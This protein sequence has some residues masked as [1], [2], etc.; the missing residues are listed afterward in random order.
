MPAKSSAQKRLMEAAAHTAGGYGGVPQKV[1]EE[2]VSKDNERGKLDKKEEHEA[3]RDH[4]ER[5][6]M[7][8]SAFLEGESRKYPVKVKRDGE[9]KYDRDLLLAAEREAAM[10]DHPDLEA[11]AKRIRE[12]EFDHGAHDDFEE[13]KHPRA[14]NGEFGSAGGSGGGNESRIHES[15]SEEKNKGPGK[16]KEAVYA[17]EENGKRRWLWHDDPDN[18]GMGPLLPITQ[19]E[20]KELV[21]SGK[22]TMRAHPDKYWKNVHPFARN[23]KDIDYSPEDMEKIGQDAIRIALDRASVRTIDADGRL[24]VA[25]SHISKATV[26]PYMGNEIPGWESLG[27]EPERV[28]QLLRDPGE[29]AQAAPTFNNIP[30]LSRHVP[31]SADEPRKDIVVGSTGTDAVFEDPYL[32]NSLVVWDSPAIGGIESREQYELSCAYRYT[33]DMTPGVYEGVPYEGVMRDIVGNHV[34]LVEVGRAGPDVVVSDSNPF[35]ETKMAKKASSKTIAVRAAV[36][37][38]LRPRLAADAALDINTLIGTVG[39]TF[40]EDDARRLVTAIQ[41]RAKLAQGANLNDLHRVIMDAAESEKDD[42]AEDAEE[43]ESE[44]ERKKREEAEAKAAADAE[45]EEQRKKE[46]EGKAMDAAI[47]AAS[48]KAEADAI[49]RMQA[50]SKAEKEVQPIIGDV[51]AM[52]SAE[53]VYKLALDHLGIEVA[54]VDPSAYRAMVRMHLAS[55]EGKKTRLAQDAAKGGDWMSENFPHAAPLVRI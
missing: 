42:K 24:H 19:K 32:K 33:P 21:S 7:P 44:E 29:L 22:A 10:H 27:L 51:A 3:E 39:A 17:I 4:K 48:A 54:D 26:N 30:L 16:P 55:N 45:E 1:G 14:E 53:A 5:E 31:V 25:V 43:E 23:W 52:D 46:E 37:A 9:W 15:G 40:A 34:A 49:K 50:I 12:H 47:K 13:S 35:Q 8:A 20:A 36:R 28:Y 18:R 38:V 2:F 41:A 6:D 11:K